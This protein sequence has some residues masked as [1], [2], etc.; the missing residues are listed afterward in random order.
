ML[1]SLDRKTP[2]D[3]LVKIEH[4]ELQAIG[5]RIAAATGILVQVN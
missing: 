5:D 2:A 3:H 1:Y 4:D